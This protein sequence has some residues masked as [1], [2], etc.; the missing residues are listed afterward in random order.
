[1][2][3]RTSAAG[4]RPGSVLARL[5]PAPRIAVVRPGRLGD[6]V[7]A[8]PA[9]RALRQACP[10]ARVTLVTSPGAAPLARR[11]PWVDEVVVPPAFPAAPGG[12]SAAPTG[13]A[14]DRFLAS[15][16]ARRFDLAIQAK[17]GGDSMNAFTQALGARVTVGQRSLAAPPLDLWMAYQTLQ[18][19]ALRL[20]D[21][22]GL[23]G[24]EGGDPRPEVPVLPEDLAE[25]AR[26][27]GPARRPLVGAHVGAGSGARRWPP[28]RFAAVLDAL[29]E[30]TGCAVA[31]I[32]TAEER[33]AARA[34]AA[35]L[36]RPNAARD[37]TGRLSLGGL[38]GLVSRL[39]LLVGND[40]GPAHLAAALDVPTVVVFG[41]ANPAQ[42]AASRRLWQRPV[43]APD[44]PC[45]LPGRRCGCP[46]DATARCLQA[47]TV[48]RV[49][50][51]ARALLRLLEREGR[52]PARPDRGSADLCA[53]G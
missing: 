49:L 19:E 14:L 24:V 44:A 17:E 6:L 18:P 30:E 41:N 21:V 28:E 32:G 2:E 1:M 5:G 31:L 48:D 38:I 51:E 7:V 36:A 53:A 16:R 45:R 13:P 37:L 27:L 15:M 22:V 34:V 52:W 29:I 25:A 11:L 9:L 10:G 20:L 12:A 47:V 42:W 50:R 43:F 33:P 23:A 39:D 4:C 26:V 3:R 35:R 46:D 40:S 8:T